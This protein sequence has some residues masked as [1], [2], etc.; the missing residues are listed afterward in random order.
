MPIN[1]NLIRPIGGN[2]TIPEGQ[3]SFR[4]LFSG[5]ASGYAAGQQWKERREAK[6]QIK[7]DFN[8]MFGQD[9]TKA[10]MNEQLASRGIAPGNFFTDF[11]QGF[12]GARA[13]NKATADPLFPEKQAEAQEDIR[14]KRRANTLD[15]QL[16]QN[17]GELM[18]EFGSLTNTEE[19]LQ[20]IQRNAGFALRPDGS[21]LFD[22]FNKITGDLH[23]IEA[24]TTAGLLKLQ[25]SKDMVDLI[26]NYGATPGDMGSLVEAKK[27]RA[28]TEILVPW[29]DKMG[30]VINDINP[31]WF[32]QA[33][34]LD[35]VKA[36]Q[37]LAGM[38]KQSSRNEAFDK[39]RLEIMAANLK[40]R[41]EELKVSQE[42][43][44]SRAAGVTRAQ[45][46]DR[47]LRALEGT[48][49]GWTMTGEDRQAAAA[50]MGKLYDS[51]VA[52]SATPPAATPDPTD[53]LG[54]FS[55]P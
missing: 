43:A 47:H 10:E 17:A 54:I 8:T 14:A 19:R 51:T 13:L 1:T 46:I 34:N 26:T 23:K 22:Q 6:G 4:A 29:A 3:D 21:R 55:K 33:G 48:P 30:V 24:S 31:E 5:A 36:A 12:L 27:Q 32:D 45:F 28:I 38:P 40:A 7:E 35:R 18:K 11:T 50:E 52:P 39:M 41:L 37:A 2:L 15:E 16:N 42:A 20:F 9:P 25:Q 49:L 44:K 53:P